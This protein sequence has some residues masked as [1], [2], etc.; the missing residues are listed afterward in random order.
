MPKQK[1]RHVD[2]PKKVG[3][4]LREARLKAGL[5]QRELSFPGCTPAYISRVEA[6]ERIPSLQL[7]RELGAQL[8]VS[9]DYLATASAEPPVAGDLV[10]A[11]AAL[12]LDELE[13]AERLYSQARTSARNKR[14]SSAAHAGLGHLAFR[15]GD[16]E[17]AIE[18]LE[19]ALDDDRDDPTAAETLGRAYATAGE[20]ERAI[21]LFEKW[22][23]RRSRD[24][25][26]MGALRFSVLLANALIDI[27][28]FGHAAEVLAGLLGSDELSA[29]PANRARIYWSQS[30]LHAL[31]GDS[32]LAARYARQAL[33]LVRLTEDT[34]FIA[35]AH[36]LLAFVELERGNAAQALELLRDGRD[37]LGESGGSVEVAK[38]KLEEARALARLGA[39]E[40]AAALAMETM[41]LLREA[42]PPDV[43][44]AYATLAE[45]FDSLDEI[46]RAQE[47]YELAIESLEAHGAPYLSDVC[48]RLADLL[49]RQ[50]K[51]EEALEVLERAV[52][53]RSDARRPF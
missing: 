47:L 38:F 2:D 3:Q 20:Y 5:S 44:R 21:A 4:R 36:Q 42:D 43:G 29:Q 35:R 10:E 19:L 51:T 18:H 34:V 46:A 14:E 23:D 7:L 27:G 22:R 32:N 16:T 39:S 45:V 25:D 17:A 1:S 11:E 52:R 28:S 12:R 9:A 41:A 40:E 37:I 50:G 15:R 31:Q 24:R 26:A 8:G 49:K 48:S 6:G 30:R 13:L 33:E 53:V